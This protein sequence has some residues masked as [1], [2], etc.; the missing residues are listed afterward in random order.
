MAK[1]D[2]YEVLGVDKTANDDEIKRA[3]K[4]MA[5]KYHPDRNPG[6]K[7][8]EEK[9]KEAAEAYDV[10]RD[11]EK[12]RRYDQ[13]GPEGV[14]GMGGFGGGQS[15]NMDDIFS[16]FGDIFGGG[17]GGGFGGFGGQRQ[18][19]RKPVF[20]GRDQR[21]RVEL[22]LNEIVNGTTKKF[23]LKNDITCSHCNG[24][25][26]EDGK[27][28]TCQTC[29]GSGYVVRTQ[30]S[31]FGMMQSQ[32]VCPECHGEGNVIKNK[33]HVCH[34]EGITK[35]ET[36]VEVNFPPGLSEGMILTLEGKGGA[37]KHNGV[38]GDLQIV[39]KEKKHEELL[40][41]GND[42]V[43]NLL[44]SV[45]MATLGC[46]VEVPTVDGK[47][48]INIEPGTQPGTVLRLKGKGIP[49][50]QGYNRGQKGD[51]VINISVYIPE[52]LNKEEKEIMKKLDTSEN[53]IPSG[54]MR[55]KIFSK[56]RAFFE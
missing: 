41:D 10:L 15:M 46:T 42:L 18:G 17:F 51:E 21:L 29:H 26:S 27:T 8:A 38:N 45:P 11:A 56:F 35:G 12:R 6:D 3:Y 14:N 19:H 47:A 40:R 9:F 52:T 50:V 25:G 16:M 37:G 53:F 33:C 22:D 31:I 34:G 13:F 55:K 28:E 43:Y 2:Y 7:D 20:K 48:K 32:S 23:K 39:I 30:Q 4:K 49:E 1:R 54:S 44:L 24:T 36:I 5:I